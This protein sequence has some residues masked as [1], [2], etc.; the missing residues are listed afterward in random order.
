MGNDVWTLLLTS[1]NK[2]AKSNGS[3][4]KVLEGTNEVKTFH[5]IPYGKGVQT[6]LKPSI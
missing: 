3:S 6:K 5:L 2:P 1:L 4:G